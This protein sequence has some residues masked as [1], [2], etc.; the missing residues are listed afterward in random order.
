VNPAAIPVTEEDIEDHIEKAAQQ[1]NLDEDQKKLLNSVFQFDDTLVQEVMKPRTELIALSV[2]T[3]L[4][5][6][7][8]TVKESNYSRYPIYQGDLDHITGIL[9]VR[10]LLTWFGKPQQKSFE[11]EQFLRKPC[12]VPTTKNIR[13][14]LREMQASRDHLAIVVDEHGGT[15]GLVT[16]E[17]IIEEVFGE[18]YDE[19][20]DQEAS[21]GEDLVLSLSETSWEVEAKVSI[22]DLEDALQMD[23]ADEETYSTLAGFILAEVG[24]IP[25]ANSIVHKNELNFTVLEADSRRVIRVRIDHVP[26]VIL[27]NKSA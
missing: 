11:L 10:N 17:D 6:I 26:T 25:E 4:E 7:L 12:F 19:H 14:L 8:S 2:E 5:D 24:S 18:I 21:E 1:G 13:E 15:A 9:H 22:R 3:K 20:D 27:E 23:I 16:V